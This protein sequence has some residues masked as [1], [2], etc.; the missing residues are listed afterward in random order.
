[1]IAM[2]RYAVYYLNTR[3]VVKAAT[4]GEAYQKVA[5]LFKIAPHH[6]T[7]ACRAFFL[8]ENHNE[9]PATGV[10]TTPKNMAKKKT[11]KTKKEDI[12]DK[13]ARIIREDKA[14]KTAEKAASKSAKPS[15]AERVEKA[16]APKR[17]SKHE[18][19]HRVAVSGS[20]AAP[21]KALSGLDAAAQVLKTYK[22]A[23][24]AKEIVGLMK[25][26]GLWSSEAKTPE[27]TI[28]SAM[29]T[30]VNKKGEQ[31]RFKKDGPLFSY[32]EPKA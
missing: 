21:A 22:K 17:I 24:S 2:N 8:R 18:R 11:A 23:M 7:T 13:V 5:V 16:A 31:S 28:Y 27:A 6:A 29:L 26:D 1:M 32:H 15:L 19:E 20:T 4:E 25:E 9:N 3:T 30:E 12:G 14:K 10:A